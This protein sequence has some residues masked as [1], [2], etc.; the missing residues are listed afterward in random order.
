[1]GFVKMTENKFTA[2][3]T[4]SPLELLIAGHGYLTAP[5]R[6]AGNSPDRFPPANDHLAGGVPYRAGPSPDLLEIMR[7]LQNLPLFPQGPNP[8]Y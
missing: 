5:L 6:S 3:A 4:R 7:Y 1:M 8:A 2:L